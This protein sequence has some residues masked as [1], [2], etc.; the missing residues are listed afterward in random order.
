MKIAYLTNSSPRSGVGSYA[1][2]LK[3]AL[4]V[5]GNTGLREYS[6]LDTRLL[7]DGEEKIT[8]TKWPG[9]LGVK[10]VNWIRLGRKL[11]R[12]FGEEKLV[13]ATNQTLSFIKT[14]KPMVVTVH[15][16]IELLEPQ[17][18]KA[19]MLNTYL[20]SGIPRAAHIVAVSHYTKKTIQDY[21]GLPS[22]R[23]TVIPN[24]VD[25]TMFHPIDNF[26]ETIGY[27]NLCRELKIAKGQ[28]LVLYVGSDHPRKN[29]GV[30]VQAFA[31]FAEMHP[32]AVFIKVG[33]AGLS[34]GRELLLQEIDRLKLRESV[35]F[36]GNVTDERLNELYNLADV[37]IFPSRFEGFGLPPLQGMA[38][39]TP[40][41]C[42]NATSLPEVVGTAALIHDPMDVAGFADDLLRV[43]GDT[44]LQQ[45]LVG[46]GLEQ[47][48]KFSWTNATQMTEKV[49]QFNI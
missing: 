40:V 6:L 14:N 21:Y 22:E 36:V 30:A 8:V 26:S 34:A 45:H 16:I 38:A 39:G 29:V 5:A 48:K 47:V 35:R 1:S 46:A 15:D 20:L 3:K 25:T 44:Q 24:G 19:S 33:E 27:E 43:V 37:L 4:V 13:H 10:S 23:I 42:S 7:I 18:K 41:V 17:D 2:A 11:P 31:K 32:Q 9:V 12:Y 28:P 49:Y